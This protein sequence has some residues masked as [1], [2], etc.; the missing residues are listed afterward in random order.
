MTQNGFLGTI[1]WIKGNLMSNSELLDKNYNNENFY[2]GSNPPPSS[3]STKPEFPFEIVGNPVV[4]HKFDVSGFTN[5]DYIKV[6]E[7]DKF[8][9]NYE[10]GICFTTPDEA[11]LTPTASK[12]LLGLF[13]GTSMEYGSLYGRLTCEPTTHGIFISSTKW[14]SNTG[15]GYQTTLCKADKITNFK[16]N[17]KYL[18]RIK[19]TLDT[20]YVIIDFSLID[21]KAETTFATYQYKSLL[22]DASDYIKG[23]ADFSHTYIGKM[24][25]ANHGS[26]Y[27][28]TI[29]LAEC[30]FRAL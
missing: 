4:D 30:Y 11:I 25:N 23:I 2:P 17:T 19:R 26:A 27:P 28:S 18:L 15:A 14:T 7:L 22:S 8:T 12:S 13:S 16:A 3:N 21:V 29:H 9:G 1:G 10:I 20:K 6:G 24:F 5:S